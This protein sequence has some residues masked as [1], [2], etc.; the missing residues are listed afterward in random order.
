SV[1]EGFSFQLQFTPRRVDPVDCTLVLTAR[2]EGGPTQTVEVAVQGAGE[3]E[4][5]PTHEALA[6]VPSAVDVLMVVDDS[7]SMQEEQGALADVGAEFFDAADRH[8]VAVRV[9]VVTTDMSAP[10]RSGRLVGMPAYFDPLAPGGLDR[11]EARVQVGTAGS[12]QEEG[13]AA[14]RAAL[15]GNR[16]PGFRRPGA[17]LAVVI[18]SDENDNSPETVSTYLDGLLA[19]AGVAPAEVHLH[20]IV[21]AQNGRAQAC[22]SQLGDADAGGRY[23][24]AVGR[25]GGRVESICAALAPGLSRIGEAT[26]GVQR[27]F[28]VPPDLAG[29]VAAVW[30]DGSPVDGWSYDPALRVVR[31]APEVFLSAGDTVLIV[32]A[33]DCAP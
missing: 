5:P 12:G 2:A 28:A 4:G 9:G 22:S 18:L 26:F 25:L 10:E 15:I 32:G 21:G 23:V 8:G 1:T 13:L 24:E 31:L 29:G 20:A 19:A 17:A 7:A 33:G 14:A 11:W 6:G 27:T 30:V 3:D 16:N